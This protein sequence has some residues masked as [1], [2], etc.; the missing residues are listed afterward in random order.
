MTIAKPDALV[1]WDDLRA[2]IA[3]CG[4]IVFLD[5]DGT[6]TPIAPRPDLAVLS[7]SMR[8]TLRILASR[9]PTAIVS[10]R[11]LA[12]IEEL[13]EI[14]GL[15]YAGSHGFDIRGPDLRC[16]VGLEARNSIN[17][18][19][20][21]VSSRL[22]G[23][24]GVLVENKT[25][26]VAV[27]FRLV[28][29]PARTLVIETTREVAAHHG[30]RVTGG[31]EIVEMR[32]NIDWDK[33][34]AVRW[35]SARHP[36]RIPL[37][38]GD[39]TTDEDAFRAIASDGIAILVSSAPRETAAAYTLRDVAAVEEFLRRLCEIPTSASA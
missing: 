36:G 12:Q 22:H 19:F 8:N 13:V 37:Y 38:I 4:V 25:F 7:P 32:P 18:A 17:T 14:P 26:S 2:R 16:Q 34:A 10:G 39:D 1:L 24:K 6:L 3:A 5:Y 30:L 21:E 35:L 28:P 23:V 27:H 15:I 31:K 9:W 20:S 11:A 29:A 33:G